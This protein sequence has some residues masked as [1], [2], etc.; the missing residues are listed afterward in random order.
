MNDNSVF[1]LAEVTALIAD[2]EAAKLYNQLRI[3][4][5]HTLVT[6]NPEYFDG[7]ASNIRILIN[8][9]R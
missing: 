1:L 3:L 7:I 9:Y 2:M 5:G 8:Q 6:Y 4:N